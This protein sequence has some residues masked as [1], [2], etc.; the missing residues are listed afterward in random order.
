MIDPLPEQA[1]QVIKRIPD[2]AT[3]RRCIAGIVQHLR[4]H[5]SPLAAE[6]LEY[7]VEAVLRDVQR[8]QLKAVIEHAARWKSQGECY[9]LPQKHEDRE[10][11]H[12]YGTAL[13]ACAQQV[14]DLAKESKWSSRRSERR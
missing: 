5:N 13:I 4:E 10:Y 2:I 11:F 12:G 9:L 6:D 3:A 14:E 1:R 8:E 7:S